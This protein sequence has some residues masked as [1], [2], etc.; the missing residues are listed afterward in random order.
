M[1][2]K[3]LRAVIYAR[4]SDRKQAEAEVSIPAQ[5]EAAQRKAAALGATVE[6]IYTDEGRSA[7]KVGN[8]PVFE[9]AV[10]YAATRGCDLFITWSSSRFARNKVEAALYKRELDHAGVRLV[11]LDMDI[12]RDTD[13]GWL[14]DGVLEIFDEM[15]SRQTAVDTKRSMIRNAEQG[16]FCG[17]VPPFGFVS[18][19]AP[20]NPKRRKLVPLPEE[21]IRLREIFELRQAGIGG[22]ALADRFNAQGIRYRGRTWK[23]DTVLHLLRNETAIGQTIFNQIDR[24]TSRRRPRDEWIVVQSH[25]PVI[26]RALWDAVQAEM[27]TAT[28][29]C[30]ARGYAKSTHLFTGLLRCEHCEGAL[31]VET[32]SGNGGRYS[33]Y[34][35]RR[36]RRSS[37]CQTRRYPTKPL[38]EY[39]TQVVFDRILDHQSLAD[40]AQ[41]MT[42]SCGQWQIDQRGRR[43]ALAQQL[44]A[45]Q[46]RNSKLYEVLEALGRDAPNLGDLTLRLRANNTEIK[47]LELQL[48]ELEAEEAPA[49]DISA[50][51]LGELASELRSLFVE[52]ASTQRLRSFYRSFICH[53]TMIGDD[54]SILYEPAAV[55]QVRGPVVHRNGDWRPVAASLR[56]AVLLVRMPDSVLAQGWARRRLGKVA[57]AVVAP[58]AAVSR[59]GRHRAG[60][61]P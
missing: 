57:P 53:V 29:S 47:A 23:K 11:Y 13:S 28:E 34:V 19:Q 18:V 41:A 3:P 5:V 40:M 43:Q 51:S 15:K 38:D 44:Q 59:S 31:T 14:L 4:V 1:T 21:A 54:A 36:G 49:P 56:T 10:E 55:L 9:S 24:R 22:K 12:D 6:K 42:A 46:Q 33:Y 50:V 58:A 45:V 61:H 27:D 25:E 20:D 32:A 52:T 60:S 26:D 2:A 39:L 30:E 35:C 7:F 8:R 17:G 16:Y 48:S 37:L